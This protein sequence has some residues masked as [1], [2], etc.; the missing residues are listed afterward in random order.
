MPVISTSKH[1][2]S[3]QK[4]I[5][6]TFLFHKKMNGILFIFAE[7]EIGLENVNALNEKFRH[8]VVSVVMILFIGKL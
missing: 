2:K 3:H 1:A 8:S 6:W 5:A 4:I 7:D